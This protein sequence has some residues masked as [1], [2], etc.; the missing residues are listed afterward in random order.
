M[1]KLKL[2][3]LFTFGLMSALLSGCTSMLLVKSEWNANQIKVNGN[4]SDWGDTMFYIPDANLTAGVRNDG[5]Y[6]YI[7]LKSTDRRQAFQI[8]GL[9]MTVWFDPT[10]G[11][12]KTFGIHFPIGRIAHGGENPRRGQRGMQMFTDTSEIDQGFAMRMPNEVELLGVGRSGSD[13]MS[14]ADLKGIELQLHTDRN[15]LIY[16]MRVPLH[17]SPDQPFAINAKGPKIG[18]GFVGGKFQMPMIRRDRGFNGGDRGDGMGGEGGEYPG[19]EGGE[20]YPGDGGEGGGYGGR[21]QFT[22]QHQFQPP[23][24]I[25]FWLKVDLASE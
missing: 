10:G 17:S 3:G 11:S 5:K 19:G 24:Q 18:V 13:R 9:G 7:I 6:M 16:E 22:Q 25:D 1:L 8:L 21:R 4:D 12:G 15:G 2:A 23:K 20:G 14:I